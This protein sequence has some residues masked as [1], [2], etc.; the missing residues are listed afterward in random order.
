MTTEHRKWSY[1]RFRVLVEQF[2]PAP[3]DPDAL[4]DVLGLQTVERDRDQFRRKCP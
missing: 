1:G 4:L 2:Q 3:H